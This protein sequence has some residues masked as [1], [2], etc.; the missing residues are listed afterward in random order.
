MPYFE[1]VS[2]AEETRSLATSAL[3][4]RSLEDIDIE[5]K[6]NIIELLTAHINDQTQP[7]DSGIRG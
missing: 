5:E 4:Q 3:M 2:K 6:G 7:L 1:R